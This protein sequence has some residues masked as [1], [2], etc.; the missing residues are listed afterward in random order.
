MS[1]GRKTEP[2][3]V[4]VGSSGGLQLAPVNLTDARR[5]VNGYHEHNE[6]PLGWKFGTGIEWDGELVGIA[7]V[8]R[9]TGRGIDQRLD[10]EV[11]RVCITERGKYKNAGSMLYG[12]ACRMAAAGGYRDAYTYTLDG[13]DAACVRAAGFVLD[14]EL[15]AR[16]TWN[17][18]SR[19]RYESNLFGESPRPAGVKKRW[20]R[21]LRTTS[22]AA[23]GVASE[24]EAG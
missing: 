11:T 14:A 6:A 3:S 4:E 20:V 17:T 13:E 19:P 5:L 10:V 7:M 1:D 23:Q 22:D 15:P 9:A 12:A 18:P 16:E 24:N 21:H 2:T 8:G